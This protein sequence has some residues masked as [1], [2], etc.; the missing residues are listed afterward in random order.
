MLSIKNYIK[1]K[2]L[3]HRLK[4]LR[5]EFSVKSRTFHAS[6]DF[7]TPNEMVVYAD[8]LRR[9]GEAI[10]LVVKEIIELS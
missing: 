4:L 6:R 9:I 3:E 2:Q 8:E 1:R 10:D 7:Y 5:Y